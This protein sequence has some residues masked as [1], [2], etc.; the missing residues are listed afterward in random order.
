MNSS[1]LV[2]IAPD[3]NEEWAELHEPFDLL[4]AINADIG[5]TKNKSFEVIGTNAAS[6]DVAWAEDAGGV[7]LTTAGAD[8]D[9]MILAPHLDAGV[10]PWTGA[11]FETDEQPAISTFIKT[12]ATIS[13]LTLWFG[14]KLSNTSVT[15][16]DADQAMIRYQDTVNDG[17]FQLITSNDGT[18]LVTDSGVTLLAST[19]YF[20][21]LRV[22]SDRSVTFFI[23]GGGK[24][25]V[26]QHSDENV[27]DGGAAL[28]TAHDLIPYLGIHANTA[29]AR[30]LTVLKPQGIAVRYK[31]S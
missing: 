12:P 21:G 23:R 2:S 10:S 8:N 18:D 28:A 26:L 14:L 13:S 16:T 19:I 9:Q 4:P 27:A 17:K 25:I 1:P 7:T 22:N 6:A 30:S 3:P 11:K 24:S 5:D 15:A 31:R 20:L 29:A